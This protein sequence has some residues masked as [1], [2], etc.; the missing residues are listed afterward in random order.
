MKEYRISELMENYTDNE[1]F[2]EGEQTVDTEKT[3]TDLLAQVKPKKRM[4]PLFKALIA[5]A[6]AVFVMAGAVVGSDLLS[7]AFTSGSGIKFKYEIDEEGNRIQWEA[8]LDYMGTLTTEDGRLYLNTGEETFDIT[9]FT[10][11]ETPYI[12]SYTNPGTG[13]AAYLIA[14]GTPEHYEFVDLFHVEQIG[15]LGFGCINGDGMHGIEV[16]IR[17]FPELREFGALT[18]SPVFFADRWLEICYD[19]CHGHDGFRDENGNYMSIN[20]NDEIVPMLSETWDG[21]DAWLISALD[22]LDL[23]V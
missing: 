11:E 10:D 2:V 23:L 4:K 20:E 14:I 19:N 7:G 1:F 15:W 3:V 17:Q 6:A 12:Y 22:Q 13:D 5:A 16:K 18:D 21:L 9:D 8:H